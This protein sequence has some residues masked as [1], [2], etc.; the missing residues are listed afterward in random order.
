MLREMVLKAGD[1]GSER[2]QIGTALV[3]KMDAIIGAS[4]TA[5]KTP[6]PMNYAGLFR[7][8]SHG[9][10]DDMPGAH[11]RDAKHNVIYDNFARLDIVAAFIE[12][13]ATKLLEDK[14]YA[15]SVS[16]IVSDL[17]HMEAELGSAAWTASGHYRN[18]LDAHSSSLPRL[19]GPIY[20]QFSSK[21]GRKLHVALKTV[22]RLPAW[23]PLCPGRSKP[24]AATEESATSSQ[25]D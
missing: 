25:S 17:R 12:K 22:K 4:A 10:I 5:K 11:V 19:G 24:V 15:T 2:R 20:K 6:R 1:V 13:T 14:A 23:K 16:A 3:E 8:S 7:L 21:Q 18:F 9:V